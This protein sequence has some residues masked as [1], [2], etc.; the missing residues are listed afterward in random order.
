MLN[1]MITIEE[2]YGISP[3]VL[4]SMNYKEALE[5][6]IKGAKQL[7][8]KLLEPHF[9]EQDTHEIRKVGKAIKFNE[10]LLKELNDSKN[11]RITHQ[12]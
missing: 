5:Y 12:I 7:M 11:L 1:S 2:L 10:E 8:I 6:K 9:M 3:Q 4:A